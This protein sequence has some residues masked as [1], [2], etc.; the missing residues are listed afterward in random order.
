MRPIVF[1]LLLLPMAATASAGPVVLPVEV[2]GAD[3]TTASI[4]V[5]VPEA[6]ASRVG[7]LWMQV[8]GLGYADMVS[9]QVNAG[10]W[11]ALNNDTAS[12]A[13]PGRSYGGI[14]GG[15]ATLKLTLPLPLAPS[16]PGPMSFDFDSTARMASR[17][18]FAFW[19]STS[20]RP[21]ALWCCPPLLFPR[22]T[23]TGGLLHAAIRPT[24]R[25]VKRSGMAPSL[26]PTTGPALRRF[27]R[28]APTAM[29]RTAAI[30]STS[31]TRNASIIARSQ[32]HGLSA[33]QAEQVASYIREL[34]VPNPGR[35]WN[36]PTNQDR[37]W[38]P[39]LRAIGLLVR[40]LIGARQ[41]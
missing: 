16:P 24:Y 23:L 37:V 14:G 28:I 41:R 40:A 34:P 25:R 5:D 15:Y 33:M 9:V 30:S 6:Q 22:K 29:P 13:E 11:L 32:F 19:P 2:V 17:A 35:P 3:G 12:V 18:D 20:Q 10:A 4:T 36:P 38:T 21:M 27:A 31:I 1:L 7:S 39:S 8:H 26:S